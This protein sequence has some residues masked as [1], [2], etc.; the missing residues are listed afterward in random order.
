MDD[1]DK[2]KVEIGARIQEIRKKRHMTQE[3]LIEKVGIKETQQMSNIERGISGVSLPRFIKICETLEIESDYLLFGVTAAGT[4][5][6]LHKYIEKMTLDQL[7]ALLELV[8]VYAKSCGID[9]V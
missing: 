7:T 6:V 8:K 4:E 2:K 3:I 1:Y 5:T 9:E